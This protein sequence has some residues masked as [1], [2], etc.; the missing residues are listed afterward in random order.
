MRPDAP[1]TGKCTSCSLGAWTPRPSLGPT[2]GSQSDVK[3]HNDKFLPPC[4]DILRNQHRSFKR[5]H[6]SVSVHLHGFSDA[7]AGLLFRNVCIV[8]ESRGVRDPFRCHRLGRAS[9]SS[10]RPC[11]VTCSLCTSLK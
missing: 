1:C 2:R 3:D 8:N 11:A 9:H 7:H 5:R 6:V 4:S 10:A